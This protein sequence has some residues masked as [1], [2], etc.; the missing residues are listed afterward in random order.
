M[1]T[2]A[3]RRLPLGAPSL[4]FLDLRIERSLGNRN[5]AIPSIV[6]GSCNKEQKSIEAI[7]TFN[8]NLSKSLI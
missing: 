6:P 5:F 1:I 2:S 7:H 4:N 8:L 3:K